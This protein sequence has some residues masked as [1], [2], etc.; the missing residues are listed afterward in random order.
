MYRQ[1]LD[2]GGRLPKTLLKEL[3]TFRGR[4]EQDITI[5]PRRMTGAEVEGKLDAFF[6]QVGLKVK[7]E[8]HTRDV[9]R[10]VIEQ[11]ISELVE[12]LST[13]A[14]AIRNN[15][16]RWPLVLID[17]LDKPDLKRSRK[18]FYG[19]RE[20][21]LQ[22][23]VPTV[24]TVSSPLF[25]SP[26][27]QAI[28]DQAIFLSNVKLHE[29]GRP[30]AHTPAGYRTMR[31]FVHKRMQPDLITPQAL[32]AAVQASGGV[33][34]EMGRIMRGAIARIRVGKRAQ[35]QTG[36][37]EKAEAEIRGEYRRFLT[38]EQRATLRAIREHNRYDEPEKVAPLLQMLAA[39]EY[40]NGE[41]WCDV[42]PA[43]HVLLDEDEG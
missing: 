36:D 20:T 27:F 23:N 35:I 26:E 32:D 16:N 28:R 19:H 18:I 4:V 11:N 31:M 38:K 12:L 8:P 29:Q 13:I 39:L 14:V 3:D 41:P 15:E 25:Y 22:P 6:A 37:V 30:E 33:F 34:R 9:V 17:D 10:Q 1:Y 5:T 7:L 42:H 2:G 21:M 43:L 24:Y 40:A